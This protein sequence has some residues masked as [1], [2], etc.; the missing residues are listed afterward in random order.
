LNE[1]IFGPKHWPHFPKIGIAR[2]GT[3]RRKAAFFQTALNKPIFKEL[4]KQEQRT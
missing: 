1:G 2:A 3:D 4:K